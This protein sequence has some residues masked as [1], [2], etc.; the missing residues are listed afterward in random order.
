MCE[1]CLQCLGTE[2]TTEDT[3]VRKSVKMVIALG[4]IAIVLIVVYGRRQQ[5]STTVTQATVV[6]PQ[7]AERAVEMTESV[8]DNIIHDRGATFVLA[9]ITTNPPAV[10]PESIVRAMQRQ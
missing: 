3:N 4:A 1:V 5:T 2:I 6:Q 7:V 8:D 10:V 9:P